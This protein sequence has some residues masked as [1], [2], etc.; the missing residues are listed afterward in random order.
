MPSVSVIVPVYNVEPYIA[1]CVR[2]LF[3]QTLQ[4]M[5]FIFV[6]DCSQDKSM[7]IM[8]QVLEEEFPARLPQVKVFRMPQNCGLR[9]ARIQG[10]S[11]A[12]GEYIIHCD[13]DDMVERDAYRI[14]YEKAIEG[15]YDIVT[16]DFRFVGLPIPRIQSQTSAPGREIA[17]ILIGKVWGNVWC[18]LFKKELW[19]DMI[20]PQFDLWEDMVFT[21]QAFTKATRFGYVPMPLYNYCVRANSM[22]WGSKEVLKHCSSIYANSQIVIECLNNQSVKCD[23]VDIISFKYRCRD[24]LLPYV[25]IRKYYRIW[26]SIFPEIDRVFL[27]TRGISFG[28]KF[29]FVLI[30]LHLYHPWKMITHPQRVLTRY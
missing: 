20:P 25:H 11:M 27:F 9:K 22:L 13:S 21:I 6:D 17:D 12:A 2:S 3:G 28:T 8:W 14:M 23:R 7:D 29:W 26:R 30:H 5:E 15:K 1:R 19:E 24:R 10:V 18:R 4:N 16:C